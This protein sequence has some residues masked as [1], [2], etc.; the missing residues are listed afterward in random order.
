MD[1][2]LFPLRSRE[3]AYYGFVQVP[4]GEYKVRMDA[5]LKGLC[6][7]VRDTVDWF[8]PPTMEM[9]KERFQSTL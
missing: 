9:V 7:T 6:Y 3:F 5:P 4:L 1:I 8:T 2:S